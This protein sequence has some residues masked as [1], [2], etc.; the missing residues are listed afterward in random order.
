[1]SAG[2]QKVSEF[3]TV[4][5]L[6]AART[7]Q[8]IEYSNIA[9]DSGVSSVTIKEWIGFLE[10]A[11]LIYLL[12]PYESNLNKRLIKM[13]KLYF[14]D[15]GLATR[16]QGWSDILLLMNSPQGGHLFETLV[17]AEILK[18]IRNYR[19][20]WQLFVWRTKEGEKE[21]IDFV[22]KT[23]ENKVVALD[24]KLAIQGIPEKVRYPASFQ[25]EFSIDEPLALITYGG[26]QLQIS[27]H[28]IVVPIAELH[29]YLKSI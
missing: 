12:K 8:F 14:L 25:K 17:L 4:I 18:F 28:C 11:D 16:L 7:G 19:K 2:I 26:R 22:I 13:P 15:T 1:M 24:A 6:L 21:E 27:T 20:D 23:S 10:R 9:N 29:D 3:H 5:G